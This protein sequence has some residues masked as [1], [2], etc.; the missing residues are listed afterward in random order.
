MAVYSGSKQF[1]GLA[2]E[3]TPGTP[4]PMNVTLPVTKFDPED[5]P[6][7]LMDKSWNGSMS[8]DYGMQQG[9]IPAD[10]NMSGNVFP[11]TIVHLLA[12]ILGDRTTTG[13]GVATT[14]ST[15]A[16]S[17]ATTIST[18]ATVAVG[19][20]VQ[21]DVGTISETRTVT[22]VAGA[23]PYTL[24][25]AALLLGHASGV[26][27][28]PLY[29]HALSLLNSGQGQPL[30]HTFTHYMGPGTNG[31]RTYA[32]ACLDSLDFKYNGSD[33]NPFSYSSK[34][35]AWPSAYAT[36]QPIAAPSGVQAIS[37]WKTTV[38]IGGA[39]NATVMDCDVNIKRK[40]EDDYTLQGSQ[41]PYSI[42]RG[43]VDVTGKMTFLADNTQGD[44]AYTAMR[45]NAQPS[46]QLNLGPVTILIPTCGYETAKPNTGRAAIEYQVTYKAIIS[47]AAAGAS[48]GL[49]PLQVTV[50]NALAGTSF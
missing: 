3:T 40:L 13:G 36:A 26:A 27:V 7:W 32:S 38:S 45:T 20:Q 21:I 28:T 35:Q 11:D 29:S 5:K 18:A 31:A 48:G 16:V 47:A 25:V 22:A 33:A 46:L 2:K 49:S 12:N 41:N 1:V 42:T 34:A 17:G 6:K 19:T 9:V 37:D 30:T 39:A 14:L 43:E 24:T 4:V 15:A 44:A 23:G 50:A 8:I 10:F